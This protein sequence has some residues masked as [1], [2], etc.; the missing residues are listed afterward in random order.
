MGG[1]K[2]K[3]LATVLT[4]PETTEKKLNMKQELFCVF[5]TR[6]GTETFNNATLSYAEAYNY[7]LDTL[8]TKVKI[9][10]K[11]KVV[12]N[13]PYDRAYNVCSVEGKRLLRNPKINEIIENRLN[14]L[15]G[16]ENAI[17]ARLAKI[18][19]KEEDDAQSLVAIRDINKLRR[20]LN[21]KPEDPEDGD[22]PQ[23]IT[24]IEI[25][26]PEGMKA[27]VT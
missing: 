8:S 27:K 23:S 17:N 24:R 11:G 19:F 21:P 10:K 22:A 16:S 7:K 13:S 2:V 6:R 9:D 1:R 3:K 20:R 4:P 26:M 5:I 15:Y 18:A 25:V 14:E 12:E